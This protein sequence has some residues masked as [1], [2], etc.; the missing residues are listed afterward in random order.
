MGLREHIPRLSLANKCLL[1]FGGA[2]VLILLAATWIPWLRMNRLVDAGQIE[3]SRQMVRTWETLEREAGGAGGEEAIDRGGVVARRLPASRAASLAPQ[4]PF[5][6][7]AVKQLATDPS[8]ADYHDSR[9]MGTT[10]EYRYARAIRAPGRGGAPT[11]DSIIVLERRSIAA[12][13]LLLLNSAYLVLAGVPVMLAALAVFWFLTNRLI[14]RPVRE[15]RATAERVRQG[16]TQT[17]SQIR[18]GDEFEE[19]SD[20]FNLML[21]DLQS[22]E[23]QL[24]TKNQAL[25]LKL[26]ELAASNDALAEA[27]RLKGEFL[28][29]ISHELRTPLNSII[30]FAE[31]LH[32]TARADAEHPD[33]PP[34][35]AKRLRYVDNILS[36][37]RHLLDLINSLLEMAK[38]EAGRI[39]VHP[40]T[41]R[42]RHACEGLL[43]LIGPLASKRGVQVALELADDLPDL[44]TDPGK[45]QQIVFNFLSNAVKF[46]EP[47]EKSGRVPQV[48][49]RAERLR[50]AGPGGGAEQVRISVIDNGPGIPPEAHARIFDKFVQ[51][52]SVYSREHA[53]TGLGLSICREL[54]A[55]LQG[56][57]HL[58]SEVGRGSMFSLI[59]PVEL[60]E[61]RLARAR[62]DARD[63]AVS[64]F[65]GV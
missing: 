16:D 40:G 36:G 19:L 46:V 18:T 15:L 53:G 39:D 57:I 34:S 1:M 35:V 54:A 12:T 61:S 9:W 43:A 31:L 38:L 5:L 26:T 45:V 6:G 52:D 23:Q 27:A 65:A 50:P 25:D 4:D 41:L 47:A 22:G 30:G 64:R 2:L 20:T 3:V 14:L 28:A 33:P 49:L 17:R 7:A 11:L 60:D 55:L 10:V 59:L 13:R 62:P 63:R 58:V 42:L 29:S 51:L 24:R 44:R 56:E 48:T 8:R 32:E 37:G 21:A